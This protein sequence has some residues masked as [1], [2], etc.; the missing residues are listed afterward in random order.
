[1]A[2]QAR[3]VRYGL[4]VLAAIVALVIA[5]VAA[6]P[7]IPERVSFS[8]ADENAMR[9]FQRIV[10][11]HGYQFH[12]DVAASGERRVVIDRITGKKFLAIRCE[13]ERWQL[14]RIPGVI[15]TPSPEC[16]L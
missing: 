13:F 9:E 3:A 4:W 5:L 16:A 11:S 10:T 12:L 14:G 8:T 1:M 15:E 2:A 6:N 7:Y